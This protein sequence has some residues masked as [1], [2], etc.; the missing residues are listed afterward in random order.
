MKRVVLALLLLPQLVYAQYRAEIFNLDM[1]AD[2]FQMKIGKTYFRDTTLVISGRSNISGL[3]ISG[4]AMLNN[5]NDSYIRVTLVDK[6]NYE[7]LVYENYPLLSDSLTTKFANIA[8][9]TVSLDNI[10]PKCLKISL[11]NAS[12]KLDSISCSNTSVMKNHN[13]K[14]PTEIQKAQVQYIVDKLNTN[15]EK[16][17]KTW[18]AGITY[19]SEKTY[20][21][22]KD[23]Y[24]DKVPELYGFEHYI[25]GVFVMPNESANSSEKALTS[26]QYVNEWDW[27]NRHGKNWMTPV[28]YHVSCGA[29]WA[30]ASISTVEAYTNLY[31]NKL[32]N[33]DLSEE[34]IVS[35]SYPNGCSGGTE[36]SAFNYIKNN[37]VVNESCFPFEN[38]ELNCSE[39]CESPD[40]KI[41][42]QDHR[43]I[44]L[45]E[46][47]IKYNL[48]KCP[49]TIA[50]GAWT[51]SMVIVGYKTIE[52]GDKI[53][54][55]NYLGSN[56]S[57]DYVII[58]SSEHQDL[59][60]KTAWLLK[61]SW[62][63]WGDNGYLYVIVDMYYPKVWRVQS[64]TGKISSLNYND[65][66]IICE[67]FDGDGYYFWGLG[68][69]P[70][71][72]PNWVPD[73]KDG[74][75]AD[76][77]K[78]KLL[79]ENNHVIGNLESLTPTISS[80]LVIN[81]NTT[82]TTRQFIYTHIR[83]ASGGKL[84]VQNILNL[85]GRVLVSIESGGELVV[86]SGVVTNVKIDFASG[87]KITL[88]NGGKLVM[89]T[90]TDFNVPIGAIA[91]IQNGEILRSNDF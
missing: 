34:E 70:S 22:K 32:L 40:E 28:K 63:P 48:F 61:N 52:V 57:V 55:G 38:T 9:E 76:H 77:T 18:R 50:I 47:S 8:L 46:D 26:N 43:Y 88:K 7:F 3:S 31:Y 91:D 41:F 12:L 65:S 15:L 72:C 2:I 30:F 84:T 27:R 19:M 33:L 14:N 80:T 86:D 64:L 17:N 42:I 23:M 81:S 59:I 36:S 71:W 53:Y 89:R 85:F 6:Y 1:S 49:L 56:S 39:K 51:H 16:H 83:I 67:D 20:S 45:I 74:N 11:L 37:G 4:I 21:E 82:Y 13:V 90:N 58:N 68:E 75:D 24:G 79:L 54:F 60:G 25:G 66:D 73:I 44:P 87:G 62:Q 35:C 5:D 29:C 78:G 69:K 10:V